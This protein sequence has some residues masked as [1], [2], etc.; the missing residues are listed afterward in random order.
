MVG[1][2]GS[3]PVAPTIFFNGLGAS[4]LAA[5]EMVSTNF[6][7][8]TIE[9]GVATLRLGWVTLRVRSAFRSS[10]QEAEE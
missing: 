8:R 7:R 10:E 4:R 1:V 2:T 5:E 9:Q 3:I 6:P